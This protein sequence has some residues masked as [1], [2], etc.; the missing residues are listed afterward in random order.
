MIQSFCIGE[1]FAFFERLARECGYSGPMVD[2]SL[3][4]DVTSGTLLTITIP[5]PNGAIA[6]AGCAAAE[7]IHYIPKEPAMQVKIDTKTGKT[8][9]KP[10]AVERGRLTGAV[11]VL[12]A[13]ATVG[14]AGASEA[15]AAVVA[16]LDQ[17]PA[18]EEP[19][20]ADGKK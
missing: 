11:G 8:H 17:L 7:E 1:S 14:I 10:T 13:L 15:S 2:A 4:S 16:I 20:K 5:L 18:E 12:D 19:A 3:R 6:A 9:I